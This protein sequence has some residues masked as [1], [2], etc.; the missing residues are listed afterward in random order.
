MSK[1]IAIDFDGCLVKNKYPDIGEEIS[2]SVEAYRRELANGA[3]FILWTCRTGEKL[4][5]AL[6]WC[7]ERGISF[8][9]INE[10]IPSHV[11]DYDEDPRK[12]YADEYWDDKAVKMPP[13]GEN[14]EASDQMSATRKMIRDLLSGSKRAFEQDSK[15]KHCADAHTEKDCDKLASARK[16][17]KGLFRKSN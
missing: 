11:L 12:V 13:D 3:E 10:N 9:A 15:D 8:S 7:K 6:E 1:I 17:V 16:T 4:Q 2:E 5:A 14:Q